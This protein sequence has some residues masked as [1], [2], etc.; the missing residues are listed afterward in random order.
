MAK[1]APA[2]QP[3]ELDCA[4]DGIALQ[5]TRWLSH[6]GTERRL[7]PKT[8]EAYARDLRQCLAFLAR[9]GARGYADALWRASGQRHQGLHGGCGAGDDIG[10]RSLMRALAGLRSFGASSNGKA[11]A[12]W[13]LVGDPAPKS[14]KS[15]PKPVP[16][17]RGEAFR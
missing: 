10:G 9:I 8:G 2:V 5:M 11:R 13:G 15:L 14:R 3:V 16:I 1:P 4:D 6:L 7:S 17:A 12:R